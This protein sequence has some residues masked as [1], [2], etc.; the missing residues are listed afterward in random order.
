MLGVPDCV[1]DSF[2]IVDLSLL[3]TF[4]YIIIINSTRHLQKF[5][6]VV[7]FRVEAPFSMEP[8]SKGHFGTNTNSEHSERK[9]EKKGLV[10]IA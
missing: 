7:H 10:S 4:F 8:P 3:I 5:N 9:G 6:C 1:Y 2:L